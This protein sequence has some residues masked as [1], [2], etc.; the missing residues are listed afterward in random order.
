RARQLGTTPPERIGVYP[1]TK[2]PSHF[3]ARGLAMEAPLVATLARHGYEGRE[4]PVWL[5]SFEVGN[6]RALA[7]VTQL[8]RVQLIEE[9]GA[10]YDFI[11]SGDA[12]RRPEL[13]KSTSDSPASRRGANAAFSRV[14]R[15]RTA[16]A[17]ASAAARLASTGLPSRNPCT[18][19]GPQRARN[20][21]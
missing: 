8:K 14:C 1:E 5:Q 13:P 17:W 3:A 18:P 7:G 19:I 4:A 10:P 9:G 2:H 16:A 6:L 12:R 20:S 21:S 15:A 11:A